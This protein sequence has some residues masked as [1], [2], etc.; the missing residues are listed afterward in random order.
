M[1]VLRIIRGLCVV[2][3][4]MG[5]ILPASALEAAQAAGPAA[6]PPPLAQRVKLLGDV[7]LDGSGQMHGWVVSGQGTPLADVPVV[8]SRAGRQPARTRTNQMGRFRVGPLRGG[9]YSM[10]VGRHAVVARAWADKT[11]PPGAADVAL[12]VCGDDVIRGQMPL[13]EFF[14]SDAVIIC[15]MVAAMIAIPIAV[16]NSRSRPSSP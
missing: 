11:A 4:S 2:W 14:A 8:L 16:H 13:E 9:S 6:A 15:G 10:L 3:G 7:R 1:D 5:L 12:I